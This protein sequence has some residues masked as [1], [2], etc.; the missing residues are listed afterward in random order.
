L[1]AGRSTH[2]ASKQVVSV[3]R[4][5]IVCT[6]A[7]YW[8]LAATQ[9]QPG[10][11]R[12]ALRESRPH[13]IAVGREHQGSRP[14]LI[15]LAFDTTLTLL[16]LPHLQITRAIMPSAQ[17]HVGE[18]DRALGEEELLV[19]VLRL[20]SDSYLRAQKKGALCLAVALSLAPYHNG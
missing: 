11:L 13:C 8:Q 9:P 3:E 6:Q 20:L 2:E 10:T 4:V 15:L 1:L 16:A 18:E 5:G 19:A 17:P 12:A 7:G 14:T